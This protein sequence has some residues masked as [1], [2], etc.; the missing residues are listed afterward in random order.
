[1]FGTAITVLC[2]GSCF[3]VAFGLRGQLVAVVSL[4]LRFGREFGFLNRLDRLHHFRGSRQLPAL[5]FGLYQ[6]FLRTR[7]L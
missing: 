2:D 5:P 4:D 1:M 6:A 3:R 7:P